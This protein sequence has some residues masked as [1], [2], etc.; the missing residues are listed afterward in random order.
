MMNF[1]K[2]LALGSVAMWVLGAAALAEGF[3]S[4]PVNIIVPY[5]PGGAVDPVARLYAQKLT[6]AW[7]VPV[8]IRNVP[9]AGG[10]IGINQAAK[11]EPD[12]YTVVLLSASVASFPHLYEKLPFDPLKDLTY[13]SLAAGL[14]L[15]LAAH[16]RL[17]AST[18]AELV[19][20]AKKN[21]GKLTYS[22]AGNGT[23]IHLGAELF[24]TT[25]GVDILHVPFK[26][27]APSVTSTVGGDTDLIYD[28]AYT[29]R[30]QVNSGKLKFIASGGERRAEAI[31][32][33]PTFAETYPGYNVV[34]WLGFVGPA[35]LPAEVAQK[36]AREIA[37]INRLPEHVEQLRSGGLEPMF[38]TPG[39]MVNL[40]QTEMIKWGKVVKDARIPKM[41]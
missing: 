5:P 27:S 25:A 7:K 39:V 22:T 2:K 3:P 29:L 17:P 14:P 36:W 6:E 16:P 9:G 15:A 35:K 37:R 40:V 11:A 24:K 23:L 30:P 33:V 21:P 4:R 8:I 18:V 28:T 1:A 26:G 12:G 19:A 31:P 10:T 34:S 20:Y 32:D 13:L 41:E 38:S